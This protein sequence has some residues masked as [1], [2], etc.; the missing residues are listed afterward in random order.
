MNQPAS[1]PLTTLLPA[2]LALG[3][4]LH[5]GAF[6][7]FPLFAAPGRVPFTL[8][9]DALTRG[10]TLHETEPADVNLLRFDAPPGAPVLLFAGEE[11]VGAKQNR[12]VNAS[13]VAPPAASTALPVSCIERGRWSAGG[14]RE[15][16]RTSQQVAYT[17][18]RRTLTGM[19]SESRARGASYVTDQQA[20]WS[21]V[22][23]RSARHTAINPT[24]AMTAI[25]ESNQE[26]LADMRDAL[27]L[28]DGQIGLVAWLGGR[29]LSLD[30]VSQPAAWASLH[31]RVVNGHALEALDA[32]DDEAA[33]TGEATARALA[34]LLET[35]ATLTAAAVGLGQELRLRTREFEGAG[36]VLDGELVQISIFGAAG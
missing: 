29:F 10:G 27:R 15:A 6:V 18:L 21:D 17:G 30:L 25:F 34:A 24:G 3:E 9:P 5:I 35:P 8:L 36:V 7:A 14:E 23:K 28:R 33:P 31:P 11:V 19:V 22:A 2:G 20:V 26:R 32:D 12:V 16:F 13:L 4:P 1:H